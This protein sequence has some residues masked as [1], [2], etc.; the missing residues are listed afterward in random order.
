VILC[1]F[2]CDAPR[3]LSNPGS[4]SKVALRPRFFLT[5]LA[6]VLEAN[7]L[8]FLSKAIE[9]S[10]K[11]PKPGVS[12]AHDGATQAPRTAESARLTSGDDS[13][14]QLDDGGGGFAGGRSVA[15][16]EQ[17]ALLVVGRTALLVDWSRFGG[18]SRSSVTSMSAAF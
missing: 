16:R 14:L 5:A 18:R 13:R 17:I 3:L 1:C 10:F 15:K 8:L 11:G 6:V 4:S 9:G 7:K 2:F 12:E